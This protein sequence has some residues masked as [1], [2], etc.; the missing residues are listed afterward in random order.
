[1]YPA[2]K[3]HN[4]DLYG[5]C[6][7]SD[8]PL[9]CSE[10][11][12]DA[13]AEIE[14]IEAPAPLMDPRDLPDP[15]DTASQWVA[16]DNGAFYI[17]WPGLMEFLVA[18]SG[19]QIFAYSLNSDC[20]EA[21]QAFFFGR[22]LSFAL[23][24]LGIEQLHATAVVIHDQVVAF[25]GEA[26]HGKSTLAAAFVQKGYPLL[27]DDLL[28]IYQKDGSFFARPGLPRLK[29]FADSANA[30]G[31]DLLGPVMAVNR[32][33]GKQITQLSKH[34]FFD[35]DARI[36]VLYALNPGPAEP[37]VVRIEEMR[38]PLAFVEICKAAFN[39][40]ITETAR[41]KEHFEMASHL[42]SSVPVKR[43]SVP[44]SLGAL[45]STCDAVLADIGI[46]RVHAST[47][48]LHPSTD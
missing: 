34:R 2:T 28:V 37:N 15:T 29:L 7:H 3:R 35:A 17:R 30:V 26:G 24:K 14:L 10:S 18:A 21:L 33:T 19:R 31:T 4:Y 25:M 41:L 42:A 45:S 36:Q 20:R 13:P 1:M 8:W 40:E 43:L 9:E 39:T 16:M 48:N 32:A 5:L 22:V 27:T 6:V 46:E 12:E 44:R 11:S 23:L 38:Q 47:G